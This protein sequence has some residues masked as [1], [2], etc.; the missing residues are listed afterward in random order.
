MVNTAL[1]N[2]ITHRN[3][4]TRTLPF[5]VSEVKNGTGLTFTFVATFVKHSG[6][7]TYDKSKDIVLSWH[8]YEGASKYL[9]TLDVKSSTDVLSSS[10]VDT[11]RRL[12]VESTELR[13]A[14]HSLKLPE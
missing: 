12:V 7:K 2:Q 6:K 11:G 10:S 5:L 1:P 4:L 3:Q 14:N 13:L 8:P 9:V